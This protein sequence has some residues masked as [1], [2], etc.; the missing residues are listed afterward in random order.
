MCQRDS[1]VCEQIYHM[2]WKNDGSIAEVKKE[3]ESRIDQVG[4]G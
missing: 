1:G 2:D 3:K 4:K